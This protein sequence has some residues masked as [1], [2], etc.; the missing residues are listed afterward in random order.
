MET[1][2]SSPVPA[3]GQK[4]SLTDIGWLASYSAR[5]LS[6]L[7]RARL[8]FQK[9]KASDIPVRNHVVGKVGS[10]IADQSREEHAATLARIRYVIPR[11][12]DRLPWRSDCLIQAIAAQNWLAALGAQSE[13]QIG[14][15]KP[16][17]GQFGAHAWLVSG[18]E[19]V[20]GGDIAQYDVILAESRLSSDSGTKS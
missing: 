15:E 20:T 2:Q 10:Q 4:P 13:I 18:G 9:L 17:D 11:L 6:E 14:V 3:K 19:I 7:V 16:E 1:A 5:G 8:I 12:S